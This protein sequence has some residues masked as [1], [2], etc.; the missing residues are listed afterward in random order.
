[1][2]IYLYTLIFHF[3]LLLIKHISLNL[4]VRISTKSILLKL[5]HLLVEVIGG[6]VILLVRAHGHGFTLFG[7]VEG[8]EV[9]VLLDLIVLAKGELG[10]V[11]ACGHVDWVCEGGFLS[12]GFGGFE[13]LSQSVVYGLTLR[14]LLLLLLLLLLFLVDCFWNWL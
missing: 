12:G 9:V 6:D 1:M 3:N 7:L 13:L 5:I 8:D 10:D 2:Q 11:D 14:R 4:S